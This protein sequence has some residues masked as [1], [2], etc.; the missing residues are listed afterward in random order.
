MARTIKQLDV[1]TSVYIEEAGVPK[2][3]VLL[4]KDDEGCIVLRA[5]AI[6][7]QRM[8]A[9]NVAKYQGSEMDDYLCDEDTGFLSLFDD[10]TSAAIIARGRP[11][12][13]EGDDECHYISRRA[14]LLTFGELCAESSTPTEPVSPLVAALM[15]WKG[16]NNPYTAREATDDEGHPV[17]WW[18]SSP[19]SATSFCHV[20]SIGASYGYNASNANGWARPA[21][22]VSAETI[23]SDEGADKIFLLPSEDS[24]TAHKRRYVAPVRRRM[25]D[26]DESANILCAFCR[27]F[28]PKDSCFDTVIHEPKIV[29]GVRSYEYHVCPDCGL[30][31]LKNLVESVTSVTN[32]RNDDEE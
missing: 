1:G 30:K 32:E 9:D 8:N 29:G 3:Y 12:Y 2:E 7:R 26:S 4:K 20:S 14:F 5:N 10:Q 27:T 31:M 17:Y 24:K 16:T 28:T 25:I 11:T 23:V 13:E 15:I 19:Y 22:N 21:L 6:K 18:L